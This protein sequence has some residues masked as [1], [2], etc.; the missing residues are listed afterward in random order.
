M[1][2]KDKVA[3]GYRAAALD[4]FASAAR[5]WATRGDAF[6]YFIAGATRR[7]PAAAQALIKRL[8]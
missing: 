2:T 6:V 7:A 1:R 8:G 4:R 3:A 5:Q